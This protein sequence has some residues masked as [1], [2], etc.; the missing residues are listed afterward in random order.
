MES[1]VFSWVRVLHSRENGVCP[2]F[3]ENVCVHEYLTGTIS[4][5]DIFFSMQATCF[6]FETKEKLNCFVLFW[7]NDN[8]SINIKETIILKKKNSGK[9]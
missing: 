9:A 4:L 2:S 8:H 1:L 3:N 5:F 7:L 6:D